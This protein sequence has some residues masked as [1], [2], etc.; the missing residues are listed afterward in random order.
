M[1]VDWL[2]NDAE[3]CLVLMV[4]QWSDLKK[5][6][7]LIWQDTCHT[8]DGYESPAWWYPQ[9]GVLSFLPR[10]NRLEMVRSENNARWSLVWLWKQ[11]E[12]EL[13]VDEPSHYGG[14]TEGGSSVGLSF[15]RISSAHDR[16]EQ[17]ITMVDSRGNNPCST[18]TSRLLCDYA[19]I[20]ATMTIIV[21]IMI[22]SLIMI[23]QPS[24]S[25]ISILPGWSPLL[26][27]PSPGSWFAHAIHH[28]LPHCGI[29][30][31]STGEHLQVDPDGSWW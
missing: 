10:I 20:L 8:M 12:W 3:W 27:S 31:I 22:M 6:A 4:K 9:D 26:A 1:T 15:V 19:N 28:H 7:D 2:V 30:S 21:I 13:Q 17:W 18:A 11:E 16:D 23:H 29:R 5:S 14:R 24:S 25:I